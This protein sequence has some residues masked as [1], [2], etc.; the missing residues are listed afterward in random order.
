VKLAAGNDC[1]TIRIQDDGIG[2][3][4]EK[5]RFE[6]GLGLV[7]IRERLHLVGGQFTMSS[8]PGTGTTLSARVPI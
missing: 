4:V 6:S 3:D 7:S 8:N 1:L 5:A 2:F